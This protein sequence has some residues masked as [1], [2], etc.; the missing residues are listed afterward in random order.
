MSS[1]LY[2][3]G[4]LV[5][6]NAALREE[7]KK[8]AKQLGIACT[9]HDLT[10]SLACGHCYAELRARQ[11]VLVEALTDLQQRYTTLFDIHARPTYPRQS[12][13]TDDLNLALATSRAALEQGER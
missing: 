1:R 9:T 10:H 7:L 8:R 3:F 4:E 6:E 2:T 12:H 13:A 5:E 11:A